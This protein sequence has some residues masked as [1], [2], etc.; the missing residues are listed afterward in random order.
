MYVLTCDLFYQEERLQRLQDRIH[1]PYDEMCIEHQVLFFI[2][3]ST[4]Q[5]INFYAL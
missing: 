1:I 5:V 2:R 4:L 3:F